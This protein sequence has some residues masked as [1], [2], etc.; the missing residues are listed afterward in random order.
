M[1]VHACVEQGYS[2]EQIES[3]LEGRREAFLQ[4][5]GMRTYAE[6]LESTLPDT[7]IR[8]QSPPRLP[9][10]LNW[11]LRMGAARLFK[12]SAV[13]PLSLA[14]L[15]QRFEVLGMCVMWGEVVG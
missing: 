2:E 10:E 9:T 3:A 15:H 8:M 6:M 11:G 12:V 5:S 4:V 1:H 14:S 7:R 13:P